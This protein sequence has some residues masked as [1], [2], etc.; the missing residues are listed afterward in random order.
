LNT[1]VIRQTFQIR[2]NGVIVNLRTSSTAIKNDIIRGG[3]H[4]EK[5]DI[6]LEQAGLPQGDATL[7][8][9]VFDILNRSTN[10]VVVDG[11][12]YAPNT[13]VHTMTTDAN[14]RAN[15]AIRLLPYGTYEIVERAPPS[16]YLNTGVIRQ[17][18][19]I[20]QH[21]VTISLNSSNT[22]I[23]NNV[24][25]G[26]VY[27]EKW[28]NEIARNAAQGAGTLEGAVFEIVNRNRNAVLIDDELFETDMVVYTLTTD[29]AG[30]AQTSND[31]LPYGIYEIREIS[32][33]YYG[34]LS[35]G[36]LSRIFEVREHGAI[37]ALNTA[38]T[39]I[40]ND[41][42]RG[43]L[44]GV[45]ISDTDAHR[46]GS[47]RFSITS[48]TTGE[49]HVI[50]TDDNGEFNTSSSWNPHS[51]NTNRG[52]TDRDGIWFGELDCLDDNVGA[53]LFDTYVIE[54]LR[55]EENEDRVLL[56][57]TVT[58]NRHDHVI[59]LGTLTNVVAPTPEID[60]T[61]R[62]SETTVNSGFVSES[63]T[64][65]D[66][67]YYSGLQ[68]GKWY[69]LK[70]LL[71]DKD[72]GEP[73]LIDDEQ[74]T[75]ERTFRA[76][77]EAG[78]VTVEFTFNSLSLEGKQIVVFQYLYQDDTQIASH[79]DI[80]DEN[81]TVTFLA[82]EP[83]PDPEPSP[84]PEPDPDPDPEPDPDPDP[85]PDPEPDPV[86][87]LEPNP[88]PDPEPAPDPKPD[89]ELAATPEPVRGSPVRM[90]S[91]PQTGR[92]G[93]PLLLFFA[94]I[95]ATTGAALVLTIYTLNRRLQD[96]AAPK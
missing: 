15:T 61:A 82:L 24:I 93:L 20:R 4:I 62:D 50:V 69:T 67:V 60:T 72:T 28:D 21:G 23:K 73:L 48:V 85:E 43:D 35:T 41:P 10:S 76:F 44:R 2:Q 95:L 27:I 19:Q 77:A 18:F 34:Y 25:R 65:I 90:P 58:V 66:T 49:S 94:C 54:E 42:I 68:P 96:R 31:L 39:A 92:D 36:V 46:M 5:W 75:A 13:I 83:E 81:Q 59:N 78:A 30:T 11:S 79:D 9:A 17:T 12:T 88:I 3:V 1:G 26:G 37:V 84:D 47:I 38:E 53:L 86:P 91:N 32:P 64:I 56:K 57:F 89:F 52:E 51:Q 71:M 16:G 74:I 55:S 29:S 22:V 40:R 8:G 70:G 7:A 87:P 14:G 6:E 45:K 80:D 33:P 63:S